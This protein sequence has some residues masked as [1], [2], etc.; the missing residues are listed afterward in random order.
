[1]TC[2]VPGCEK[3]AQKGFH[4]CADIHQPGWVRSDERRDAD[5][6]S[7]QSYDDAVA[8][9]CKREAELIAVFATPVH[10]PPRND[11]ES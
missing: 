8:A 2:A 4:F 5:L 3:P 11:T 6:T 9:F 10:Y 1:M 7:D